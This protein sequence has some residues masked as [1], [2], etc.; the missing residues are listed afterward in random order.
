MPRNFF[1]LLWM[2]SAAHER[3]NEAAADAAEFYPRGTPSCLSAYC[4][5][6]AAADA[7]EF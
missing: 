5:N 1:S 3:F 6:E 4:F 2:N 7:A